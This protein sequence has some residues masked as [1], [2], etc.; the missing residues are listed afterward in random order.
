LVDETPSRP[1]DVVAPLCVVPH[2][3]SSGSTFMASVDP[4]EVGSI[5]GW[6]RSDPEQ[7]AWSSVGSPPQWQRRAA[8]SN[9][10]P[11]VSGGRG[12]TGSDSARIHSLNISAICNR[13]KENQLT[14]SQ[15][16]RR[17]TITPVT[18]LISSGT[19]RRISRVTRVP[20]INS[21]SHVACPPLIKPPPAA[22]SRQIRFHPQLIFHVPGAH[23]PTKT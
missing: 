17:H 11:A 16:H 2:V 12:S 14:C 15:S 19:N 23:L 9:G 13:I 1:C 10:R 4:S 8:S 18:H 22:N 7:T 5:A 6:S 20:G 21:S 3:K